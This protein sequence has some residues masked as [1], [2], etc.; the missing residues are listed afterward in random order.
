V[1]P[2]RVCARELE[3]DQRVLEAA[4]ESWSWAF[5]LVKKQLNDGPRTPEIVE[6][7]AADVSNRLRADAEA[8]RNLN[9]YLARGS[10]QSKNPLLRFN[11]ARYP[12][13]PRDE[14]GGLLFLL[15]RLLD[16]GPG[17]VVS[18]RRL[19]AGNFEICRL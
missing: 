2:F 6:D 16:H 5:W 18:H 8:G 19:V 13:R 3:I 11:V 12:W 7:V 4:K 10:R 9:G 17:E 1:P 15:L 14:S